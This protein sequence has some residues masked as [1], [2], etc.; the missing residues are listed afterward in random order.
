MTGKNE[1]DGYVSL[2]YVNWC[3]NNGAYG[4]EMQSVLSEKEDP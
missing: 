4:S 2:S 1:W 3:C